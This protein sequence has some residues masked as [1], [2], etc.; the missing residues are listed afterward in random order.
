METTKLIEEYLGDTLNEHERKIFEERLS[1]DMEFNRL[2]QL[3]KEVNE[4]IRDKDF[5]QFYSLVKQVDAA[6]FETQHDSLPV[7]HP[8]KPA[9]RYKSMMRYAALFLVLL[10]TAAILRLTLFA[11]TKP[12]KLFDQYY[13]PYHSDLVMR[14]TQTKETALGNAML[15][16]SRGDY[17]T[18]LQSLNELISENQ[19][20]PFV[21]FYK[22]LTCLALDQA[23]E[24]IRSFRAIA[25]EW[26]HPLLEHRNWYLALALLQNNNTEEAVVVFN[27]I[28]E[29]NGYYSEKANQILRKLGS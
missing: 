4:G 14:S 7:E 2:F 24:A 19:G 16:Y 11:V 20:N 6:Y 21:W 13:T 8:L 1:C 25:P 18:A 22:G 15:D 26:N 9:F 5:H 27:E 17:A 29:F 3:H 28:E 12:D 23:S 10:G